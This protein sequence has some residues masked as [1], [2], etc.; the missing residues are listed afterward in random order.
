MK[1][2][3]PHLS[4][5]EKIRDAYDE[6]AI[7]YNSRYQIIQFLKYGIMLPKLIHIPS[8]PSVEIKGPI[9]DVGGG[10]GLFLEFLDLLSLYWRGEYVKDEKIRKILEFTSYYIMRITGIKPVSLVH[11][12]MIICDI[13]FNMLL[14]A[15]SLRND[16]ALRGLVACD[17]S[18]LPFRNKFYLTLIAFTVFQNIKNTESAIYQ[19]FRTI[20][21]LGTVGISIL[22]KHSNKL[23]FVNLLGTYFEQIQPITIENIIEKLQKSNGQFDKY[24][25]TSI[26]H[27]LECVEDFFLS[28]KKPQGKENEIIRI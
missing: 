20:Q 10:T 23:E 24:S 22:R 26:L 19:F 15:R 6:S 2:P 16:T 21:D 9:L 7:Y 18:H 11:N 13:S 28:A 27:E 14:H 8:L 3:K 5:E 4:K 17:C 12:L 1:S 25:P